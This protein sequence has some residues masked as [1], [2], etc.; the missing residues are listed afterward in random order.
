MK[1]QEKRER[2]A[3]EAKAQEEREKG[4]KAQEERERQ[5]REAKAQ[6]EQEWQAAA[7]LGTI[8][9]TDSLGTVEGI[10]Q[11]ITEYGTI[12][13]TYTVYKDSRPTPEAYTTTSTWTET[14]LTTC[15]STALVGESTAMFF[16]S[17]CI[18]TSCGGSQ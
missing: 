15:V 6:E 2:L 5:A 4:V 18:A 1:A 3:R 8:D 13:G 14:A 7:R 16:T 12:I 17:V 11:D 9:V 10:Q